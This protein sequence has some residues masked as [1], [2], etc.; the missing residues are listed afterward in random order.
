MDMK[1]YNKK[2]LILF[3]GVEYIQVL[4]RFMRLFMCAVSFIKVYTNCI[5]FIKVCQSKH[6]VV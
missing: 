6:M 3:T 1:D 5:Q 2:I 4:S